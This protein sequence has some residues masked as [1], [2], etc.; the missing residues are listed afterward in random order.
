M[1]VQGR[2]G[3]VRRASAVLVLLA[4]VVVCALAVHATPAAAGT[5][6]TTTT[7]TT[8]TTTTGPD[9][10]WTWPLTGPPPVTRGYDP[11]AVRYGTGH[12][13][14]D[15]GA[16]AGDPV[17]AAGAG[18]V[19]Y[20]GLLAGRGVVVVV[21]GELR[22]TYEPV[23]A[24]VG[25]GQ[26]VGVGSVLGRLAGGHAGCAT[27]ACLHWGL[28]RGD[29][30]LDPLSL[31]QAGPVRLL[32]V[33]GTLS[34]SPAGPPPGPAVVSL[35]VSR[36]APAAVAAPAG[37]AAP[38]AAPPA[39]G[40]DARTP[41]DL[42]ASATSTTALAASALLVG[43]ALLVRPRLPD[44]PSVGPVSRGRQRARRARGSRRPRR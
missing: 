17:L 3:R 44:R 38:G 43:V 41:L 37:G 34:G 8:T 20:A 36:P 15:L 28:R 18:R 16:R 14:V 13:G 42:R 31:V 32:P 39:P 19:S 7:P 25:V 21:H 24:Q 33:P 5:T 29:Q 9:R 30:Y 22:T 35:P 27:Q 26:V 12:R 4:A 1:G 40:Q 6:A 10:G 23:S 11:P 2:T